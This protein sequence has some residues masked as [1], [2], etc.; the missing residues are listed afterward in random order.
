LDEKIQQTVGGNTLTTGKQWEQES[1]YYFFFTIT[2]KIP[3]DF[4]CSKENEETFV[5]VG[6]P[7]ESRRREFQIPLP[8]CE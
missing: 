7:H 3:R 8:L 1:Y 2:G 4:C 6:N 5:R